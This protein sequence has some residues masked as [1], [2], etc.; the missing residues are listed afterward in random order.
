MFL[1]YIGNDNNRATG[2]WRYKELPYKAE[3]S[4]STWEFG[5][6]MYSCSSTLFALQA[7]RAG[8]FRSASV[9]VGVL[10]AD[11]CRHGLSGQQG[12]C[13]QRPGSQKCTSVCWQNLQGIIK[14]KMF[15]LF[16]QVCQLTL[17]HACIYR[18]LILV[19]LVTCYV[20]TIIHLVGGWFLSSGLHQ[21][22]VL[23]YAITIMFVLYS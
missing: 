18:S 11:S 15:L 2:K 6:R 8:T 4:V 10:P 14:T 12:L 17:F 13:A 16:I 20:R 23:I 19:W 3:A 9:S 5:I 1:C 22:Y 21:R 7:W